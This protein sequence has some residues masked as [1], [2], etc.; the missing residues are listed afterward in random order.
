VFVALGLVAVDGFHAPGVTESE[1]DVLIAAA[2]GEPVPAVHTL[3]ADDEA[4]SEGFDGVKKRL[5]RGGQVAA[6]TGLAV[7]IEDDK[8]EGPG[9][10][11]DA[12]V[13]SDIGGGLEVT[14]EGP[15]VGVR[16]SEGTPLHLR[17]RKPS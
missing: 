9:V 4:L 8:K 2:V 3:A 10:E 6:E 15:P 12:G 7:V 13:E 16:R 1:G 11:I 17:T 14:H 5:R